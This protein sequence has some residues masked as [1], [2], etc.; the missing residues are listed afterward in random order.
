MYEADLPKGARIVIEHGEI[1]QKGEFYRDSK[2]VCTQ[3]L[4][5]ENCLKYV[6]Y[7]SLR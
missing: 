5:C 3:R 7:Q 4:M 1:L 6:E 2:A